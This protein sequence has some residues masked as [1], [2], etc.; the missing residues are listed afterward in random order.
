MLMVC[1]AGWAAPPVHLSSGAEVEGATGYDSNLFLQ[2]A[3]SPDSPNYHAY[4][5]AFLRLHPVLTGATVGSGF[6]VELR[7]GADLTQTF[8]AGR[9]YLQDADLS[10]SIPEYTVGRPLLKATYG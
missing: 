9:L 5:G 3:A 10:L 2:I 6:R 8:G 1:G 7:Y 4:S